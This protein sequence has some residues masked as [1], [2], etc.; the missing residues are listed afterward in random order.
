MKI[1][2]S[3]LQFLGNFFGLLYMKTKES[4]QCKMVRKAEE[5]EMFFRKDTSVKLTGGEDEHSD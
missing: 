5:R 4:S 1:W 2:D 3:F